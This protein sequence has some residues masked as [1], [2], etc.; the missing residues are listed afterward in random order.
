MKVSF[1]QVKCHCGIAKLTIAHEKQGEE[2][3]QI[4]VHVQFMTP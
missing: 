2:I 3:Y 4:L 1:P